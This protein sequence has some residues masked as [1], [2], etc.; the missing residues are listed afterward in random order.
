MDSARSNHLLNSLLTQLPPAE[1]DPCLSEQ[2]GPH[3]ADQAVPVRL[4][5]A[6][7]WE[8]MYPIIRH[9]YVAERTKL[10]ELMVI[11]EHK[12]GFKAT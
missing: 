3:E 10:R 2:R 11:M 8:A 7:E 1:I 4:H 6:Q 5:S 9:L 12:H